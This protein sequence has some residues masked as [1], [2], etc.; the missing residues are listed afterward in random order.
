MPSTTFLRVDF[1]RIAELIDRTLGV[2]HGSLET[3]FRV[4]LSSH[5]CLEVRVVL[6]LVLRCR[7]PESDKHGAEKLARDLLGLTR[8]QFAE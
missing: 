3:L 1:Q 5:E 8:L 2:A 6:D 7:D 4:V